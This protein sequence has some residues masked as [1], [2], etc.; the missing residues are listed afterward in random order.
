[1]TS[2]TA[3]DRRVAYNPD[4]QEGYRWGRGPWSSYWADATGHAEWLRSEV[5]THPDGRAVVWDGIDW[6]E[7]QSVDAPRRPVWEKIALPGAL[8]G[9]LSVIALLLFG[10]GRAV[11]YVLA[12]E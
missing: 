11:R 9:A 8:S 3:P 7:I 10:F 4:T 2:P 12:N 6:I 5:A 1:M